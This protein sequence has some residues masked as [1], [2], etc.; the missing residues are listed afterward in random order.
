LR[1][2]GLYG[3][4]SR[5]AVGRNPGVP[6]GVHAGEIGVD[7][8]EPDLG[9]EQTGFV[10]AG[11]GQKAV[12]LGEHLTGLARCVFGTIGRSLTMPLYTT[13]RLM[14]VLGWIRLISLMAFP[15]KKNKGKKLR[16]EIKSNDSCRS[17]AS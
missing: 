8:L 6:H 14:R 5:R 12:D 15:V 7:V 1:E 16:Q 11:I 13:T 17:T 4:A 10:D 9:G 3:R 2:L